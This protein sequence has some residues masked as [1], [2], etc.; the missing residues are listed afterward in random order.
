MVVL[1]SLSLEYVNHVYRGISVKNCSRNEKGQSKTRVHL[2]S[3]EQ[4][5]QSNKEW[6]PFFHNIKNKQHLLNSFVTYLCADD[7]IK[8][9]PLSILV[10][11]EN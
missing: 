4:K 3:S 9:C 10:I 2:Q 8:L 5:M 11:N 1:K 6:L 7:F